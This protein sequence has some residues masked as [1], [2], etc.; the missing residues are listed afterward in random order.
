MRAVAKLAGRAW[1][2]ARAYSFEGKLAAFVI[3][4]GQSNALGF[5]MDG[6][7]LPGEYGKPDPL[8]MIWS[9]R[10]AAYE[11]M[12]PGVN[13]GTPGQPQA[14]AAEVAFAR[15][16]RQ[17]NPKEPL[18]IVKSAKGSTGLAAD[19]QR[20]DWSPNSAGEMFDATAG[21]VTAARAQA[22]WPGVD[23]VFI[24]QGEQDASQE[25]WARDYERN[26]ADWFAAIRSRWMDDPDGEI[27]FARVGEELT[28]AELVGRAQA[29]GDAADPHAR[30]VETAAF[31]RQAD[32][33]HYS[34][35]A[36]LQVGQAFGRLFEAE[37][38]AA[39]N[40]GRWFRLARRGRSG[41]R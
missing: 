11:V 22:G 10:A 3:F 29:L 21:Q 12:Q 35:V 32:R 13:T 5:G 38:T 14:W 23:A 6:S 41:G 26:M 16:F 33:L 39:R 17:A 18:Y 24:V 9:Q 25:A 31:P 4:A 36:H 34:A 30:S 20:L 28:H 19:P 15:A 8:T 1:A 7:T 2:R 37:R 27:F 40:E